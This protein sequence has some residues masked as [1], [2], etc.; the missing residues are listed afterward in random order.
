MYIKFSIYFSHTDVAISNWW[1][2]LN[3]AQMSVPVSLF[4][5]NQRK[6]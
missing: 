1:V 4:S 5:M 3:D 2:Y 6:K